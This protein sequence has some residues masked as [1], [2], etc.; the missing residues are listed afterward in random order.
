MANYPIEGNVRK[1]SYCNLMPSGDPST[2]HTWHRNASFLLPSSNASFGIILAHFLF[3]S[4]KRGY[5]TS[6]IYPYKENLERCIF[7]MPSKSFLSASNKRLNK[8]L[9]ADSGRCRQWQNHSNLISRLNWLDGPNSMGV[10]QWSRLIILGIIF[11][12]YHAHVLLSFSF[13]LFLFL[14]SCLPFPKWFWK[15]QGDGWDQ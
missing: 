14:L 3:Y 9:S 8:R 15:G 4:T 6:V 5:P 1:E 11:G 7:Q 10:Q 12:C 13:L 2:V